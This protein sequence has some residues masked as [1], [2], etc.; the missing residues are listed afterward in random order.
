MSMIYVALA[1]VAAALAAWLIC[2]TALRAMRR[3]VRNLWPHS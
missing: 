2:R 3:Y 1:V